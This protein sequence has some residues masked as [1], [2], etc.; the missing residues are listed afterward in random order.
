MGEDAPTAATTSSRREGNDQATTSQ[1]D[2]TWADTA[3]VL[4][5]GMG[6]HQRRATLRGLVSNLSR[7]G[8]VEVGG[9][10]TE[11]SG[12]G[13][14]LRPVPLR[15]KAGP[16]LEAA[17]DVYE[18]YWAPHAA[19]K[20]TARSVMSWLLRQ[21]FV[22]GTALRKP[23]KKT[24][25]DLGWISV[26]VL[27]FLVG[28]LVLFL[29]LSELTHQAYCS[30]RDVSISAEDQIKKCLL[31]GVDATNLTPTGLDNVANKVTGEVTLAGRQQVGNSFR[32]LVQGLGESIGRVLSSAGTSA[33]NLYY[34]VTGDEKRKDLTL[35]ELAPGAV[36]GEATQVGAATPLPYLL[37]L[38][39]LLWLSTMILRRFLELK[40]DRFAK[41]GWLV[42]Q[43]AVLVAA[44]VS[45]GYKYGMLVSGVI[46][47]ILTFIAFQFQGKQV[48]LVGFELI[49]LL[50]LVQL[51]PPILVAF[52]WVLAIAYVIIQ[53]VRR[54]VSESLGDVQV[55]TTL[56]EL[57]S[58][59]PVR[60]AI[61]TESEK[62]MQVVDERD[63]RR[64]VLIGHS[65]GSVVAINLLQRLQLRET[66]LLGR[67][68][69]VITLGTAL[70]KVRF[71]FARKTDPYSADA[72]TML[73]YL[74]AKLK[75]MRDSAALEES[76]AV[77]EALKELDF[78]VK[79]TGAQDDFGEREHRCW[80]NVWYRN[81]PVA[82]PITTFGNKDSR[83]LKW[84]DVQTDL[85][86]LTRDGTR[87]LV[88]NLDLGWRA[89]PVAKFLWPHSDYWTDR[90]F[91]R[92]V[93][94]VVFP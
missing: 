25:Y 37:P 3:V 22:P 2:P 7:V 11:R 93:E 94:R 21:T 5:H 26:S 49:I 27:A 24:V 74:K 90:R 10:Y 4:I 53:L 39:G 59:F 13:K 66:D 6:E 16:E 12:F 14:D 48:F 73:S 45:I 83:N 61:L 19:G 85:G 47:A 50:L 84:K 52:G 71:F 42:M 20:T 68:D 40:A 1:S 44:I 35:S 8:P 69:S 41:F 30:R 88:V 15:V 81:D 36:L 51:I 67:I 55:Y 92:V 18:V 60:E 65:L 63:Y 9:D 46:F 33:Q 43:V 89:Q 62:L 78:G 70:E 77:H 23:S 58:H 56:D 72:I 32:N 76:A 82:N 86:E 17:A 54:F 75:R 80:I 91:L 31:Y 57:S 64:V 38:A 87:H 29:T 79:I 34:N 28:L